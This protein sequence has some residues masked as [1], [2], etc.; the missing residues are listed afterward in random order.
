MVG[1]PEPVRLPAPGV[2]GWGLL[3][4]YR[5]HDALSGH[6]HRHDGSEDGDQS[7]GDDAGE[8]DGGDHGDGRPCHHGPD[9]N[10]WRDNCH[11]IRDR[12]EPGHINRQA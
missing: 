8:G 4:R 5:T 7:R 6:A 1:G 9:E 3:P 10:C 2:S 12:E 11:A